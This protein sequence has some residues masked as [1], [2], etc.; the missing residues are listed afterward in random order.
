MYLQKFP[1]HYLRQLRAINY[2]QNIF[3]NAKY[4]YIYIL[5]RNTVP[6]NSRHISWLYPQRSQQPHTTWRIV[7]YVALTQE[8]RR[9]RTVTEVFWQ[10][11]TQKINPTNYKSYTIKRHL[12]IYFPFR[13][14]IDC[15][16]NAINYTPD[17]TTIYPFR[18]YNDVTR[19]AI[20]WRTLEPRGE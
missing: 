1:V 12:V 4:I 17:I 19:R 10:Y 3:A 16:H 5:Q 7:S 18:I 6:T 14:T 8:I 9:Q 11:Y 2:S 13:S 20:S 15:R